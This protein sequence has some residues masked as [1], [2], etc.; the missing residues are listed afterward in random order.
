VSVAF[1]ELSGEIQE[2]GYWGGARDS[3]PL[4]RTGSNPSDELSVE[5]D[6]REHHRRVSQ[7]S[8]LR[9]MAGGEQPQAY[10]GDQHAQGQLDPAAETEAEPSGDRPEGEH[11]QAGGEQQERGTRGVHTEAVAGGFGGL[12]DGPLPGH[13]GFGVLSIVATPLTRWGVA[14]V[15]GMAAAFPAVIL[16]LFAREFF[17]LKAPPLTVWPAAI[18]I[19]AIVW[20]S[21]RFFVPGDQPVRP[22]GRI[23][24]I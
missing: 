8:P 20:S 9:A 10:R 14:V 15:A 17:A 3:T 12:G 19:A 16:V 23:V 13:L 22:R 5:T 6:A 18:G 21:A 7:Y 2:H 1:A 11:H 4:A 24:N